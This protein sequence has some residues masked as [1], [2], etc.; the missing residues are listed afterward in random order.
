MSMKLAYLAA[1]A[2]GMY[3]GSCLHDQRL[4]ATLRAQGRDVV[5]VPLYTPLTTDEPPTAMTRVLYGGLNTWL[6]MAVPFWRRVPGWLD[7]WADAAPVL[8]LIGRAAGSTRA[9]TLG[10]MTLSVLRGEAGAQRREVDK[11]VEFLAALRPDVVYLPNLL[12]LGPARAIKRRLRVPVT[13]GLTGEDLFVGQLP[14]P[15]RTQVRAEIAAR[16]ADVDAFIALSDYYARH[17]Q[18]YFA[19]PAARVRRLTMGIHADEVPLAAPT[20]ATPTLGYLARLCPEKGLDQLVTAWLQLR[21]AGVPCRLRVAGYLGALDRAF[22][23]HEQAR[24]RAAGLVDECDWLPSPSRADKYRFLSTL[25]TLA[26]PTRYAEAKGFYVLEALAAGVPVVLPQ[27]GSFPELLAAT[28][29][30]VLHPPGDTAALVAALREL[31]T[32]EPRR[33]TL[34]AAGREAVQAHFT[35]ARM[36]DEAWALF[37]DVSQGRRITG[38]T[39]VSPVPMTGGTPVPPTA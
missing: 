16:A 28:G 5:L 38:G 10:P 32:D 18:E 29:G 1:G 14:E 25:H 27:H 24:V 15:Y 39:G 2:G 4:A 23:R 26:V 22:V 30:G 3:C 11:L 17:A 6:Q 36:A 31:L 33:A 12:L 19:L 9:A 7:R 8:R 35:A 37:S 13:C 20:G 34:A 21:A